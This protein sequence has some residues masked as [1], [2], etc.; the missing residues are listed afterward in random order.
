MQA[1]Q[2]QSVGLLQS[3]YSNPSKGSYGARHRALADRDF[4]VVATLMV[5]RRRQPI[6]TPLHLL[7]A[8]KTVM[9]ISR[10]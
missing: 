4:T 8:R 6:M 2:V 3:S 7:L 5:R 1:I 10:Q 9:L